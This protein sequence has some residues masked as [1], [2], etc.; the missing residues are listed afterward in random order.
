L[1]VLSA[2]ISTEGTALFDAADIIKN[3][4]EELKILTEWPP[5]MFPTYL[6]SLAEV[7]SCTIG[8]F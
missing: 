1:P 3:A 2:E 4:M 7:N 6:Q 8:Q 5:G